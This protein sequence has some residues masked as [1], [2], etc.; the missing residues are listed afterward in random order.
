MHCP[1]RADRRAQGRIR[2]VENRANEPNAA[3]MAANGARGWAKCDERSHRAARRGPNGANEPTEPRPREIGANEP[4]GRPVG[5]A[6]GANE[7]IVDLTEWQ[8]INA[9]MRRD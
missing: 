3:R 5:W 4:T 6:I 1:S 8:T 9:W 7:A 2:R